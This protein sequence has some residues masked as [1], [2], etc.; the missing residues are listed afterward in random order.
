MT[1]VLPS[2]PIYFS[3]LVFDSKVKILWKSNNVSI[4]IYAVIEVNYNVSKTP[5]LPWKSLYSDIF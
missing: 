2:F 3:P 4:A 1:T 5:T